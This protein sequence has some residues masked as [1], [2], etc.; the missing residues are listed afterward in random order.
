MEETFDVVVVGGGAAGLSAALA[1]SRARRAVLVVD[2]GSPRNA[3]A[4]HVHNYLG[5]EGSSPADLLS[6]GRAEVSS[7][8][9]EVVSGTVISATARDGGGFGVELARGSTVETRQL[10]LSTG[11]I[12]ELPDL[13]GLGERWGRD[14]VHCPYCHGWEVRDK[15]LAILGTGPLAVHQAQL[16]RQWSEDITLFVHTAPH[17][18]SEEREQLVARRIAIAEGVIAAV[19][20]NDDRISGL[21]L[22]SG[23]VLPCEAVVVSALFAPG[24][25]DLLDSLGLEAAP[26]EMA[27]H[28]IG[29]YIAADATGAT[30]VPGVWV[31][32]NVAD[33]RATVISSAARGLEVA[34]A[35]N[36]DLIAADTRQAVATHRRRE[37]EAAEQFWDEFYRQHDRVWSGNPNAALVREVA[38]LPPGTALDLGCAEGADAIWLAE[39]GWRVTGVDIS[40]LALDRACEHAAAAGVADRTE[41]QQHDLGVSFPG[42]T[43]DLVCA[44]FLHSYLDLPRDEILRRAAAAVVPG[45]VFL[46]VG[47][48][49]PPSVEPHGHPT[50]HL[51]TPQE[52]LDALAL[53]PV[54]WELQRSGEHEDSLVG[55]DGQPATR[56]NNT[57][58]LRRNSG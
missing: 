37:S 5:R 22:R 53:P 18:T 48:A 12:D 9:G 41:W 24:A 56:T 4:G 19:E 10:L 28:A 36:A 54:E 32:G 52:V 39:R 2:A 26:L 35:L 1:L 38:D 15:A 44:Q 50:V 8:G 47:H 29:T 7:Y 21:R 49:R 17:P 20:V 14:V 51:P 30:A 42:G 43:F 33:P 3:L 46:V 27:G 11:L 55:P 6:T 25:A 31:A 13:P 45:G 58:K 57:L 23:E 34:A 40:R 16:S